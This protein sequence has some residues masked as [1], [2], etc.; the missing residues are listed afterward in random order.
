V[1]SRT[2]SEH[3][4]G[5]CGRPKRRFLT[6]LLA[7]AACGAGIFLI[8]QAM[9][10]VRDLPMTDDEVRAAALALLPPEEAPLSS[11]ELKKAAFGRHLFSDPGLSGGGQVSCASC[12]KPDQFFSDGHPSPT[13]KLRRAPENSADSLNTPAIV[14][15]RL[16]RWAFWDGRSDSLGAQALSVLEDPQYMASS[17]VHVVRYVAQRYRETYE[18]VFGPFPAVLSPPDLPMHGLPR[19]ASSNLTVE[20]AAQALATL[21]GKGKLLDILIHAQTLRLAPAMELGRRALERPVPP[22]T[23]TTSYDELDA[24]VQNALNLVFARVGQAIASYERQ[25]VTEPSSFDRFAA[26]LGAGETV[27]Q[28]S[29][30]AHWSASEITGFKLFMGPGGCAGCHSGPGLSDQRFHN[31]GLPY[32]SGPVHLGRA[33][34]VLTALNDPFNCYS[35]YFPAET[36]PTT[37]ETSRCPMLSLLDVNDSASIGAFKTPSLRNVIATAPYM[38]DGRFQTLREV[39]EFYSSL[40]GD[41][42]IGTRDPSLEPL[43][44]TG[45]EMDA[46]ESFLRTLSS[47]VRDRSASTEVSVRGG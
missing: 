22:L 27:E 20:T 14:N 41:P 39:L 43:R 15:G 42:A 28:A 7:V 25:L 45:E 16:L 40:E 26:R 32:R 8:P 1:L 6:I 33:G 21:H 17:R 12:H 18:E 9:K 24:D 2:I 47:P 3:R 5:D 46:L 23:W 35:G 44:L 10:R 19:P 30:E 29:Q 13:A 4:R 31:L 37:D 11:L 36:V 38:H 34:G